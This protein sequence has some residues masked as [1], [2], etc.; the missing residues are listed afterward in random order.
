MDELSYNYVCSIFSSSSIIMLTYICSCNLL[1]MWCLFWIL[2]T[3]C[4]K[5]SRRCLSVY[6]R[7]NID[8]QGLGKEEGPSRLGFSEEAN[9]VLLDLFTHYPPDDAEL[10]GDAVK[11]SGDKATRVQWKTDG[12]F[13]RPTMQE[14]DIVKKLEILTSKTSGQLKKV[15][16]SRLICFVLPFILASPRIPTFIPAIGG[17]FKWVLRVVHMCTDRWRQ[18]QTSNIILQGS[19]L[20]YSG[21]SPGIFFVPKLLSQLEPESFTH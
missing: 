4:R 21:K 2:F 14:H 20:F 15:V 9:Q 19:H 13:C 3:N 6:K 16:Y 8:T 10:S 11:K 18:I 12:A 5:G 7:N 17:V 1:F